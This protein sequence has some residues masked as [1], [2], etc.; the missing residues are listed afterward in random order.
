MPTSSDEPV[1][2]PITLPQLV[3]VVEEIEPDHMELGSLPPSEDLVDPIN[4]PTAE[5]AD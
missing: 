1:P 4:V 2:V 3:D 5:D